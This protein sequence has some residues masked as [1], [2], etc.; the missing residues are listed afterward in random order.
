MARLASQ[1]RFT[2]LDVSKMGVILLLARAQQARIA[3]IPLP[4]ED[5]EKLYVFL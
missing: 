2:K 3:Q 4:V 1:L 5:T